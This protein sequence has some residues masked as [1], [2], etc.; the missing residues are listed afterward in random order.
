[1]TVLRHHPWLALAFVLALGLT[2]F[3]GVRFVRH[4]IYWSDP[5]HR[6]EQVAGWMTVGYIARS[7][8]LDPHDID[9]EA[10]LPRPDQTATGRPMTLQ[11]IA[12]E[13]GVPVGEVIADVEGA[14]ARL[15]LREAAQELSP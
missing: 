7:W 9:A 6:N 4:A 3:F 8:G 12:D 1:M 10:G 15:R 5:A 2:A 11:Q 13:R 14:I